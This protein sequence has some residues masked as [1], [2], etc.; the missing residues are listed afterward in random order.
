MEP[1]ANFSRG[2]K[3]RARKRR[4]CTEQAAQQ[5]GCSLSLASPSPARAELEH[6]AVSGGAPGAPGQEVAVPASSSVSDSPSESEAASACTSGSPAAATAESAEQG[7]GGNLEG[8]PS[9]LG[10]R[11]PGWPPP[12]AEL[13]SSHAPDSLP[14]QRR[15]RLRL[16]ALPCPQPNEALRWRIFPLVRNAIALAEKEL[17]AHEICRFV[18]G[19][20]P[21]V[22]LANISTARLRALVALVLT[23]NT[24][25]SRLVQRAKW[26]ALPAME[27]VVIFVPRL[28]CGHLT[29]L[30]VAWCCNTK[31]P[32]EVVLCYCAHRHA[33]AECSE[34]RHLWLFVLVG[35]GPHG[36]HNR[37]GHAKDPETIR[38]GS[39][40]VQV[41]GDAKGIVRA[42][43]WDSTLHIA[44]S[45]LASPALLP[46]AA[47]EVVQQYTEQCS[48]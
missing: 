36:H 48:P 1:G 6:V 11:P 47:I 26:Y 3:K 32:K 2:Q 12:G 17:D 5:A 42:D 22:C 23:H 7:S 38:V 46:D 18:E 4:R 31:R 28:T 20:L 16:A 21:A 33:T 44:L 29:A 25:R 15:Q 34:E 19:N 43:W 45:L 27:D 9:P 8:W 35:A 39:A 10:L 24:R 41:H 37:L 14:L 40:E 30:W 13:L